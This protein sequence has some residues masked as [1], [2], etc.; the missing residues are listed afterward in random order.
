MHTDE[1]I[2]HSIVDAFEVV[3]GPAELC[4]VQFNAG[5]GTKI[6]TPLVPCD[7]GLVII[8][9]PRLPR[10]FDIVKMLRVS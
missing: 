10:V 1:Q 5:I 4:L 8:V 9:P 2:G 7:V 3:V 6:N